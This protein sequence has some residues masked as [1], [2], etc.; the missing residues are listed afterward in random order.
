MRVIPANQRRRLRLALGFACLLLAIVF[1]RSLEAPFNILIRGPAISLWRSDYLRL[2]QERDGF[3]ITF[4]S[5]DAFPP[6]EVN[7]TLPVPPIIHH[8]FLGP[9]DW[10][11]FRNGTLTACR[12]SCMDM[13]PGFEFKFWNDSNAEEFIHARF[14]GTLETWKSYPHLIQKADSLRYMVLH[15]FGGETVSVALH[16]HYQI[17]KI[18]A[19]SNYRL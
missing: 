16:Q 11:L 15:E 9:N 5:Y 18:R 13:H 10:T 3:D 17:R 7:R 2:S 4:Q 1:W 12:Q 14:P 19:K 8:I 6:A